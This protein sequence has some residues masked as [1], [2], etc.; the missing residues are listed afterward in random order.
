MHTTVIALV[1]ILVGAYVNHF[2]STVRF[3]MQ[4]Q[5]DL[6]KE[7]STYLA[8]HLI[9]VVIQ[10]DLAKAQQAYADST[11]A[12]EELLVRVATL[13]PPSVH[14]LMRDALRGVTPSAMPP[15]SELLQIVSKYRETMRSVLAAMADSFTAWGRL[16]GWWESARVVR[17]LALL[18]TNRRG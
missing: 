5:A 10:Q 13:F 14:A 8:T 18:R 15:Q 9:T 6:I 12:G 3:R 17:A 2:L 7:V 1:S 16:R 11:I 4:L